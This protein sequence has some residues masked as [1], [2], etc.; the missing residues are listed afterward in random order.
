MCV[1]VVL[2]EGLKQLSFNLTHC[3]DRS[4]SKFDDKGYVGGRNR[5]LYV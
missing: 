1:E 2:G 3:V 4:S 5:M